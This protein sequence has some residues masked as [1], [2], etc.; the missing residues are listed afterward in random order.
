VSETSTHAP[1]TRPRRPPDAT[2]WVVT[3]VAVI[4]LVWSVS[5]LDA[6]WSR[7]LDA[8]HDIYTL[9][10]LMFTQMEWDDVGGSVRAMWESIMMAWLGTLIAAV[11]AIPLALGA[12]LNVAPRPLV[13]VIR[14]VFNVLRAVPDLILAL[15][16]LPILGLS[17]STG[18][19][20][21]GIGSVGTLGKLTAEILEA[22]D[23]GPLEAADAV[24]ASA[25]QRVRWAVIPQALPEIASLVLYRFEIN[26]RVSAV[27][28]VVG[29]GGI[30]LVLTQNLRFREYGTA[31]V[32]LIV[33]VV[34]TVAV[35][36]L[37]GWIRGRII[38]GSDRIEVT[39]T[40]LLAESLAT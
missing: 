20:A 22:I 24:G 28:G 19:V 32:A 38:A 3:G 35:D 15:A 16:I 12:A 27:L 11:F 9:F 34:A 14:Q 8:P 13:F 21:V 10:R 36:T 1:S 23:A 31:G 5:G 25:V 26:I 37:S 17:T 7:L 2:K 40:H 6:K 18:I 4:A 29:A 39:D 33:V 30:G